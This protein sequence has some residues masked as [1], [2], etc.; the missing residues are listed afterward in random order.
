MG[1]TSSVS[2]EVSSTNKQARSTTA[3]A[4][5]TTYQ[6]QNMNKVSMEYARCAVALQGVANNLLSGSRQYLTK[7]NTTGLVAD[8]LVTLM[9]DLAESY[10]KISSAADQLSRRSR[11]AGSAVTEHEKNLRDKWSQAN[12]EYEKLRSS[13]SE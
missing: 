8:T 5:T 13:K 12:S 2:K 4:G 1:S 10:Q 7:D 9:T 11:V 6:V 3:A